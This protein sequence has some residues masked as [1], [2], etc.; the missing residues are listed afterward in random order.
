MQC[1]FFCLVIYPYSEN[2]AKTRLFFRSCEKIFSLKGKYSFPTGKI[3]CCLRLVLWLV[4]KPYRLFA[5]SRFFSC[6]NFNC[7]SNISRQGMAKPTL[8]AS[9][10][11]LEYRYSISMGRWKS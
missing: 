5:F 4:K 9:A 2:Q 1:A 6:K 10:I 11:A 7:A 3:Y 8:C